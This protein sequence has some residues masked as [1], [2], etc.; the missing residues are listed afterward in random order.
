M[1][2]ATSGSATTPPKLSY[3]DYAYGAGFFLDAIAGYAAFAAAHP[4]IAADLFAV[5]VGFTALGRYL[6]SLGD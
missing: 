1:A 6:Q 2:D 4:A 3:S 5:G